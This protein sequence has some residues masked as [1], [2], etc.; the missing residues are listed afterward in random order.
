MLVDRREELFVLESGNFVLVKWLNES[1]LD[2]DWG[3]FNQ[4]ILL[5][6]E[7][8]IFITREWESF[9]GFDEEFCDDEVFLLIEKGRVLLDVVA[10]FVVI[11]GK[12]VDFHV[13][14]MINFL[15]AFLQELLKDHHNLIQVFLFLEVGPFA[16]LLQYALE[17]L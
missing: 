13:D 7:F 10:D 3:F 9:K 1:L 8:L 11:F 5:F 6:E 4:V 16:I 14:D 2:E 17:L 12:G 15:L